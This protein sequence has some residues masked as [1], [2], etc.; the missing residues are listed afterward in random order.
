MIVVIVAA[1]VTGLFV[2]SWLGPAMAIVSAV[3][4]GL[5]G[6]AVSDEALPVEGATQVDPATAQRIAAL[7]A[8][9]VELSGT[10]RQFE[11]VLAGIDEGV[12]AIDKALRITVVNRAARELLGL[13]ESSIGRPLVEAVQIT[14][15]HNLVAQSVTG[16]HSTEMNMGTNPD[17]IIDARARPLAAGGVV[18][19]MLDVTELRRLAAVRR[20][21]VTNVSHELRTPVGVIRAG[22][23]ALLNGG[24]DDPEAGRRFASALSRNAERLGNLVDDLLDLSRIE[25]SRYRVE[26]ARLA[27]SSIAD[28]VAESLRARAEVRGVVIDVQIDGEVAVTADETALDQVLVNLVDNAIKYGDAN[29]RVEIAATIED[30]RV[31]IEVRDDGAGIRQ[32]DAARV[33]E[34]FYRVDPGRSREAGGTGLGLSIAKHLVE[35]MGGT[36]GVQARLPRGSVFWIEL[37]QAELEQ[38]SP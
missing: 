33:F 13:T 2:G 30:E 10:Q 8:Q 19:M 35:A 37:P 6:A 27:V 15:L 38:A 11:V 4:I 29:G 16:P 17:R 5:A 32:K 25:A 34:R 21:F 12:L 9:I 1:G 14:A 31:R 26:S 23:D 24:L 7:D 36:I 22:A 20:D 18:V 3:V 28:R